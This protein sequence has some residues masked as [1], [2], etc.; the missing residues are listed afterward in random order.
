MTFTYATV[1][2][3]GKLHEN[4]YRI[5]ACKYV[6]SST[7]HPGNDSVFSSAFFHIRNSMEARGGSVSTI[8]ISH[9]KPRPQCV[10]S[11]LSALSVFMAQLLQESSISVQVQEHF[12]LLHTAY[13]GPFKIAIVLTFS[14]PVNHSS[15]CC[16]VQSSDCRWPVQ[17]HTQTIPCFNSILATNNP[18]SLHD[19]SRCFS[20]ERHDLKTV[21]AKVTRLQYI[22][23]RSK[24]P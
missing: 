6:H 3:N 17:W 8:L 4:T 5:Q 20:R 19:F 15:Y 24:L 13:I 2:D 22:S 1:V 14:H 10:G 21:E 9:Y 16:P 18:T 11:T 12:K 7:Y 23:T